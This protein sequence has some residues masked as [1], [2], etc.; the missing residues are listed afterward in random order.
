MKEVDRIVNPSATDNLPQFTMNVEFI[1]D[2]SVL[3]LLKMLLRIFP[4]L[5]FSGT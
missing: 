2:W 1:D 4:T 3:L 5:A